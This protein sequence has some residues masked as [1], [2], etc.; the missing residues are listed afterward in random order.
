MNKTDPFP[1]FSPILVLVGIENDAYNI[2]KTDV[3]GM[4]V[5]STRFQ[6]PKKH[7]STRYSNDNHATHQPDHISLDVIC[8][9]LPDVWYWE[10][11]TTMILGSGVR[12]STLTHLQALESLHLHG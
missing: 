9:R 1:T 12:V 10:T 3:N 11:Q 8:R 5:Y 4:I 2:S 6:N 7:I